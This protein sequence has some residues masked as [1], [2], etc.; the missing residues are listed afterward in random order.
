MRLERAR[1]RLALIVRCSE[2]DA[3]LAHGLS[4]RQCANP[5]ETPPQVTVEAS[6]STH[7]PGL[8]LDVAASFSF[9]SLGYEPNK[10]A[11]QLIAALDRT[12]RSHFFC[13]AANASHN[14]SKYS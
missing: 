9:A 11:L 6:T 2:S 1:T 7:I 8:M 10:L 5:M 14:G 4:S 12:L 3:V 13:F